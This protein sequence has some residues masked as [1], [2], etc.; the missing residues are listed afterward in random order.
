MT[1]TVD[2]TIYPMELVLRTCHTFTARCFVSPH[3]VADGL[4]EIELIAREERDSL[5]ELAGDFSNALLDSHL[6]ALIA[7]ETHTIRELLIAQAFC[8]ADL[9]D[10]RDIES[11]ESA[12]P[13]RIAG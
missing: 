6:R 8:E 13:R 9:L 10:H 12:D 2:L 11:D 7:G 5:R 4:L 3:A 1:V